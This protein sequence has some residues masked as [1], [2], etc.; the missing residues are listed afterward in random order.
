MAS[1]PDR[2]YPE[3]A[4]GADGVIQFVFTGNTSGAYHLVIRDGT[5]EVEAGE[6]VDPTVTVSAPGEAWLAV[7]N[8][9]SSPLQLL[10]QGKLKVK[11]SLAMAGKFQSMFKPGSEL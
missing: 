2:F 4:Q 6:H 11:G 5:L 9:E 1:Y 3:K 10:M 7:N 8:G